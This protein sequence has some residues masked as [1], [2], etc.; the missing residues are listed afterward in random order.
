[1]GHDEGPVDWGD[2]I[3]KIRSRKFFIQALAEEF[4]VDISVLTTPHGWKERALR[5]QAAV[6]L[7]KKYGLNYHETAKI[8]Q[9]TPGTISK[10][11]GD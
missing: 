10:F 1:M 3:I 7:I 2:R 9:I 5:R 11:N 4:D 8:L 6:L